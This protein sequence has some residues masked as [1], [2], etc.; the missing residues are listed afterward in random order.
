MGGGPLGTDT[1][2]GICCGN[3]VLP[4]KVGYFGAKWSLSKR[5]SKKPRVCGIYGC[6]CCR[7]I[8]G[9]GCII[10]AAVGGAILG[11]EDG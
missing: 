5:P 4:S 8:A 6:T 10:I 1:G 3:I 9:F 11:M 2:C 7:I